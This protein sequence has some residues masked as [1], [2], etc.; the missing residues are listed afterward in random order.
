M[1]VF[2]LLTGRGNNTLKDKNI[3]P[4]LGKPLLSYPARAARQA[5]GAENLFV[6][7]DD[8]AILEA[9][10]EEG[11]RKIRRPKEISGPT[12]KHIDAITHGLEFIRRDTGVSVDILVVMLANSATVKSEWI[13]KGIAWIREDPS[14]SAVVPAYVEQDHHPYRAK[15]LNS[16]GFLV[17][18]FDL[19]PV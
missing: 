11:F 14:I 16:D 7:S 13:A 15:Q 10:A 3:I 2:C 18:Y 5:I 6:S 4:V 8:D 19:P 12:A 1:N 17:P 9:A